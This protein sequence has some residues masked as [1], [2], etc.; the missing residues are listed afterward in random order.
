MREC[1]LTPSGLIFY[2]VG[3]LCEQLLDVVGLGELSRGLSQDDIAL[4]FSRKF[5]IFFL[6][7]LLKIRASYLLGCDYRDE[8]LVLALKGRFKRQVD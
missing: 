1:D 6:L 5:L 2:A 4:P 3:L 7:L 8:P